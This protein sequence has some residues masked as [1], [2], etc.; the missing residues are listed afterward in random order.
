MDKVCAIFSLLCVV[1]GC[2]TWYR[3]TS[4]HCE[5]GVEVDGKIICHEDENTVDASMGFCMT[6]DSVTESVLVGS[7]PYGYSS[8]MTNRMYP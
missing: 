7:C 8:N 4:G 1:S 5:C 3:N 6:Y 2:P